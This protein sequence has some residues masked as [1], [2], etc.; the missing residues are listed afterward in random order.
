MKNW[1]VG[2]GRC[3]SR[4]RAALGLID[5]KTRVDQGLWFDQEVPHKN[6]QLQLSLQKETWKSGV[7]FF[8]FTHFQRQISP[9][10]SDARALKTCLAQNRIHF[11]FTSR[12]RIAIIS[13]WCGAIAIWNTHPPP[14]TAKIWDFFREKK[15][16]LGSPDHALRHN[17][18]HYPEAWFSG[19][20]PIGTCVRS[21]MD[22]AKGFFSW[23]IS[24]RDRTIDH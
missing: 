16:T 15:A 8:L 21:W 5:L 14:N 18:V 6:V 10:R 11:P 17:S 20:Q 4:A 9:L 2:S 3:R 23:S 13:L 12:N 1:E 7:V 19:A 24:R 22:Q